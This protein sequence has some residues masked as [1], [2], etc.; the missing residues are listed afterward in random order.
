MFK[1][2]SGLLL[3]TSLHICK[4]L[5]LGACQKIDVLVYAERTCV[6]MASGTSVTSGKSV[7]WQCTVVGFSADTLHKALY[8]MVVKIN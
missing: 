6:I 3:V 7:G 2:D 4:H 1:S 8:I 5:A